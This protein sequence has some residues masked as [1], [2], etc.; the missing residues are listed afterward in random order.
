MRPDAF[1]VQQLGQGV[2]AFVR[3]DP[4]DD[5]AN[6]NVLV[7]I[8]DVDVI[9]VDGNLAL[10]SAAGTIA[11]I[12]RLTPLPVR[13][14]IN[15]HWHDD[16][17]LGNSQYAEVFPG[18]EFI[19]HPYT[20][21]RIFD[22]VAPSLEGYKTA[23]PEEL[24]RLE[25]RI[26]KG[27]RS[28]G[29]PFTDEDRASLERVSA[30]FRAMVSELPGMQITPPTLLA[31]HTMTMWRGTREIRLMFLGRGNTAGDLIVH[32]PTEGI[33]ATGDL[34]VQPIPYGFGVYP[35][36]WIDTLDRLKALGA[37]VLMPGHGELQRDTQYVTTVQELLGVLRR[38]MRE[39]VARGLTLEQAR[40]ALDLESFRARF[41]GRD[42]RR[43]AQFAEL[44]VSP[45]S[46]RAYLEARG[47]LK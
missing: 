47:E 42:S 13:Y 21:Q 25:T 19:A 4:V 8:S 30:L 24:R 20:R 45:A 46:E 35:G 41:A 31:E 36:E 10:S 38:Q 33:V 26:A 17:V 40:A 5:A 44:F 23:Y 34:V 3:R 2:Y 7:I 18:V 22:T 15:T 11:A 16:H 1:D 27:T 6:S 9:V 28:D 39:A 12:R 37:R 14:V 29:K 32:L 43:R